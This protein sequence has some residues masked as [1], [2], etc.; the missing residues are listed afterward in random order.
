MFLTNH[1]LRLRARFHMFVRGC[2]GISAAK[3]LAHNGISDFI[4]V[5]A[6]N[7][8]GGRMANSRF[9][10]VT[11]ETGAGW[12][13]GVGGE[14]LNPI[15]KL[16]NECNLRT[17]PITPMLDSTFT[18]PGIYITNYNSFGNDI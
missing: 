5:E 2:A 15:W 9:G 11:V 3:V 14:D 8:I 18:I 7:R 16:A 12:I 4:I 6:A 10:G 17:C 13:A 1:S